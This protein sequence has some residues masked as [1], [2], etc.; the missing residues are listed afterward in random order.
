MSSPGS[1]TQ[2]IFELR[3]G[4]RAAVQNLW[5]RYFQRLVE[6][7]RRRL[8]GVPRQAADEE[9]VA[10]SAFESFCRAAE[11][12]RFPKLEDREDLWQLLVVLADRKAAN[13]ARDARAQ[14]RGG[15]RVRH[16]SALLDHQG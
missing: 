15:G 16:L 7:V 9:D 5:E 1:V 8:R 13:L 11:Q 6:L 4:Q 12:G 2:W 3:A 14:K 10:L